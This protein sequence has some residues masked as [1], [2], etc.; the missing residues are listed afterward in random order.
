MDDNILKLL[1]HMKYIYIITLNLFVF[2]G[3]LAI[4]Y[5]DKPILSLIY[6]IPLLFI[7]VYEF[8]IFNK[9]QPD[10][11]NLKEINSKKLLYSSIINGI[12]GFLVLPIVNLMFN[13]S[14]NTKTIILSLLNGIFFT[15][16]PYLTLKLQKKFNKKMLN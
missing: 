8:W 11:S 14:I 13:D 16:I 9:F 15:F 2:Y 6:L 12:G 5:L 4:F 10:N 7:S 3:L 1:T